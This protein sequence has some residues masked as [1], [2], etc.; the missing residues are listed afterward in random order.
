[1]NKS[2]DLEKRLTKIVVK[3]GEERKEAIIESIP[4]DG[5]SSD[6]VSLSSQYMQKFIAQVSV[7]ELDVL[8]LDKGKFESLVKQDIFLKL[9]NR[10]QLDLA[11]IKNEKI[12]AKGRDNN[13]AV[14]AINVENN[15]IFK[16]MGYDTKNKVIA[17]VSTS[18]QKENS[19][20]VL[21]WLLNIK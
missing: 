8:V 12:E 18:K 21:K 11:S 13:M 4:L 9:D 2:N 19:T 17:I 7:G 1:M 6:N 14:Y 5:S 20:L 10:N 15:K 3:E 16:D